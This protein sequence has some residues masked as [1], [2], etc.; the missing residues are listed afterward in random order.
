MVYIL[1]EYYGMMHFNPDLR[2]DEKPLIRTLLQERVFAV[3]RGQ[4]Q[5]AFL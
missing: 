3:Y 1:F 4:R 5:M 2:L